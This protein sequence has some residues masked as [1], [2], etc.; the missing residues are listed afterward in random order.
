MNHQLSHPRSYAPSGT[1]PS[2]SRA[3]G[4]APGA[5]ARPFQRLFSRGASLT[6]AFV[7][8]AL[9]AA[10][11]GGSSDS[12]GSTGGDLSPRMAQIA[13]TVEVAKSVDMKVLVISADRH[14]SRVTW[15]ITSILDQIGV[16]YDKMVLKGANATALQMVAG[17]LSDGAGNGKYQGIILETGDLP[18][19][20]TELRRSRLRHPAIRAP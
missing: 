1:E 14:R 9:L 20:E 19:E 2:S 10:C 17:T 15:P 13:G 11:G 3:T 6:V 7:A 16:P 18:Y 8:A 12:V 4:F 5:L